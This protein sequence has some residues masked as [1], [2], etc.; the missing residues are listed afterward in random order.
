MIHENI[1]TLLSLD[2][3]VIEQPGGHIVKFQ[4]HRVKMKDY[5]CHKICYNLALY[6][7]CGKLIMRIG[8]TQVGKARANN[9]CIAQKSHRN[10]FGQDQL[11]N[12]DNVATYQFVDVCQLLKDF[13][14]EVD[15]ILNIKKNNR[16]G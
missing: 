10:Y 16:K 5:A 7:P 2:G 6:D 9:K 14:L 13:W 1:D 15:K 8:N 3:E 12:A 4:V 11:A